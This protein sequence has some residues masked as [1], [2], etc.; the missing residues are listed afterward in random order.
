MD[1]VNTSMPTGRPRSAGTS[2]DSIERMKRIKKEAAEIGRLYRSP[3]MIKDWQGAFEFPIQSA[4]TS[5]FGTRRVFNGEMKSFHQGLDLKAP[6]G[7]PIAAPA[8]GKVVLAKDLYMTGNTIILDHGY[9]L[10]TIY[11]HM[12]VM[13][14]KLGTL[15]KKGELLGL[16]G[17]TGRASGPHLHWGAVVHL[18]KVNPMDLIRVLN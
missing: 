13:R 4:V 2:K 17:M 10:F 16:S 9:G 12:S 6:E 1:E 11:A 14:A 15:V 7:T 18:L 3:R 8:G 5:Q